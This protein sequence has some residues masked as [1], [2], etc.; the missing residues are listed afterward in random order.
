MGPHIS[1]LVF[2]SQ[3]TTEQEKESLKSHINNPT[4]KAFDR[5]KKDPPS[6]RRSYIYKTMGGSCIR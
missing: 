3:G 6:E 2:S 5:A 4:I 1:L